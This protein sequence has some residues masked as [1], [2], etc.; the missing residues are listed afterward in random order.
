MLKDVKSKYDSFYQQ[1]NQ[2]SNEK[3]AIDSTEKLPK[4]IVLLLVL[5]IFPNRL[6]GGVENN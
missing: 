4:E 1:L 5:M 6:T 2:S 3:L